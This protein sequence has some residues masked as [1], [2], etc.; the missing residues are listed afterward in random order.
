MR[1]R[2]ARS[3]APAVLARRTTA[4]EPHASLDRDMPA[5]DDGIRLTSSEDTGVFTLSLDRQENVINPA[6]VEAL[7]TGVDVVERA[8]HP[9]ALVI[10]GVGKFFSNGL[11]LEYKRDHP[12]GVAPL[13]DAFQRV[14]ARLLVLD[15]RSV[16]ALN[17][18]AFGAGLFLALACDY[19]V[20]RTERG[21]LN[22][23]E[24]HVGLH[25]TKGFAE[26]A[27]VNAC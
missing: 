3:A 4:A 10:T 18:H 1:H 20:M 7:S 25:L 21:Y 17:G 11:D 23:P 22:F 26:L 24:L 13:V 16:A 6:F 9:K 15:C 2:R 27:K 5:N 12:E 14:L 8:P 19:R